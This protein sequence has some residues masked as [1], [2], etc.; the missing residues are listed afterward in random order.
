MFGQKHNSISGRTI[1]VN[2]LQ[3]K[4]IRIYKVL[5]IK[6]MQFILLEVKI[7]KENIIKYFTCILSTDRTRPSFLQ[8]AGTL[9]AVVFG[10]DHLS[11]PRLAFNMAFNIAEKP[12]ERNKF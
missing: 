5:H 7:A 8:K 3:V 4:Y 10:G 6:Q 1:K 9:T 2:N 11:Q 12:K